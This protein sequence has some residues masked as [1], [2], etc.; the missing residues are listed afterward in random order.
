MLGI[1]S[2]LKSNLKTF[3][4]LNIMEIVNIQ[5]I[6]RPE[7]QVFYYKFLRA[8]FQ[9]T[10]PVAVSVFKRKYILDY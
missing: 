10:F 7:A 8:A 4:Y 3:E 5:R 9:R 2:N 1:N 6:C